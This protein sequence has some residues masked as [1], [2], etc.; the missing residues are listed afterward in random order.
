PGD[1]V[2][3]GGG[4]VGAY[5]ERRVISEKHLIK[6]PDGVSDA[7]AAGIMVKG[8][9]AFFLLRR[10]YLVKRDTPVLIHAA[11]GGVGLLLCQ[12]AKHL[13]AKVIGTVSSDEKAALAKANGCDYPIIYTRENVAER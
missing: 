5:V 13:G 4:P 11:A 6:I 3:Y 12:W 8:L 1:R 7:L 9:T 2:A 10:T